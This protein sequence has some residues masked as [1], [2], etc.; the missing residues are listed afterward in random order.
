MILQFIVKNNDYDKKY[1]S[2]FEYRAQG[3]LGE[4]GKNI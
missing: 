4:W 2:C 1:V 3:P